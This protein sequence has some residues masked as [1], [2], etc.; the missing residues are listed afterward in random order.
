[1]GRMPVYGEDACIYEC[2]YANYLMA[3]DED[4][5]EEEEEEE[6]ASNASKSLVSSNQASAGRA[7]PFY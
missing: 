2:I 6:T 7:H 5:V 4:E 1:M 3:C